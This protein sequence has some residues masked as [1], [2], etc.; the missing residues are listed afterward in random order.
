[1]NDPVCMTHDGSPE[2]D[3]LLHYT[4]CGLDNVYLASGYQVRE[5]GGER[6]IS[7]RDVEDLHEAIALFLARKRKVLSGK[8]VRF[9]RK[10]LGL[11]QRELGAWLK[12][13]DQSIARYEKDQTVLDGAADT[14]LRLL[15]AAKAEES[16]DVRAELERIQES[17][18]ASDADLT[19]E[20]ADDEWR[21]AA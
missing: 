16:I 14:L 5:I 17:D 11:T 3:E 2:R 20:R 7:V 8:E 9:I 21:A 6:Y 15:V 10:Y 19:F 18:D 13:S 4:A 12:V 1:M